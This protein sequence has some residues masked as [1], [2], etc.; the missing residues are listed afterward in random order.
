MEHHAINDIEQTPTK[1]WMYKWPD[2][3][4]VSKIISM[5]C[6]GKSPS[7]YGLYPEVIKNESKRLVQILNTIIR[8]A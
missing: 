2:K 1:H 5:L 6:N 7:A 4:K 8:D 3:D